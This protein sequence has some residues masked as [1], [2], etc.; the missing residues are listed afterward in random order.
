MRNRYEP[1]EGPP[2]AAR[3]A[4]LRRLSRLTW[5]ATQ[6]SAVT[7]VGFATL[8]ARTAPAQ[9]ADQATTAPSTEPS[10]SVSS[11]GTPTPPASQRHHAVG[12]KS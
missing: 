7:A 8:F 5:R 4:G 11:A 10:A 3:S 1:P 2:G 6:L 9:T 12:R